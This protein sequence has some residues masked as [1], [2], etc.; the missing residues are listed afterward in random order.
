MN[1]PF[2]YIKLFNIFPNVGRV[3]M[4]FKRVKQILSSAI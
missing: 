3:K 2:T 4:A 1:N